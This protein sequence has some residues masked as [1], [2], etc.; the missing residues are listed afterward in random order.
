MVPI[1]GLND[2]EIEDF[3]RLAMDTSYQIRFI[4]LM[5]YGRNAQWNKEHFISAAEIAARVEKVA[6]LTLIRFKVPGVARYYRLNK[7]NGIV[8]FISPVSNHFCMTCN[9]LRLTSK[10]MIRPCLFSDAEIDIGTVVRRG[11]GMDEIQEI[12][13]KAVNEKSVGH[14]GNLETG[15]NSMSEIGG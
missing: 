10:G 7:G 3:V 9:R 2:C 1:K 6:A 11:A 15:T 12:L 4:E 8:G 13:L 14:R 5:P